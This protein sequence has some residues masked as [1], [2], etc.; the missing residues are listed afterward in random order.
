[1]HVLNSAGLKAVT[2]AMLDNGRIK[3]YS[4]PAFNTKNFRIEQAVPE[5]GYRLGCKHSAAMAGVRE[6]IARDHAARTGL[7]CDA[8][9]V[10]PST[11]KTI[12]LAECVDAAEL[13]GAL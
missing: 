12:K 10:T 4:F 13:L 7:T 6:Q 3:D 8:I 5:G 1:M 2:N 11:T 9:A